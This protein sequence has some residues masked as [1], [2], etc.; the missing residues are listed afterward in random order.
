VTYHF[1]DIHNIATGAR[2]AA[3]EDSLLRTLAALWQELDPLK[4]GHGVKPP[5]ADMVKEIS[6]LT[7]D[8]KRE[9]ASLPQAIAAVV[10]E[11]ADNSLAA[12]RMTR[13]DGR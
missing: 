5:D 7:R 12:I 6:D 3:I 10:I 13:D 1:A 9:A 2:G 4:D 8:L 11:I